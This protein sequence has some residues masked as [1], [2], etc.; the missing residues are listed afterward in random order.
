TCTLA[1]A[2]VGDHVLTATYAGDENFA[3]STSD[4]V[5]QSVLMAQT[6]LHIESH[7]PDPSV[8]SQP[9]TV[10]A[11]AWVLEPGVG[12][13]TAPI[14]VGDG[15]DSCTIPTANGSCVIVL[16]TRGPRT[17]LATYEGDADFGPS[18]E[19]MGHRVNEAPFVF[20]ENYFLLEDH[21]LA[22][23]AAEGV[24]ANDFDSDGDPI[25]VANAGTLTASGIGGI[26]VLAADGS[27]TYT[28][29]ADANG[30]ATFDYV[31]TDG[32][33]SVT[34]TA[35][36]SVAPVND[37]PTFTLAADPVWPPGMSGKEF[38]SGFAT[39][40]SL[41]GP[42]EEGQQVLGWPARIVKDPNGIFEV[43]PFVNMDG[44]LCYTLNGRG[45]TATI[46]VAAQDNGGTDD[47]G[48]DTS[49]EQMF[50]ISVGAGTDLAVTIDDGV[51]FVGVGDTLD[52]VIVVSN[53]GPDHAAGA[54]VKDLLP[55]NLIDASWTCTA[56]TGA[57]CSPGGSGD[58]DETI[59]LAPG[60][61][62]V[63]TLTATLAQSPEAPLENS[64]SVTAPSG[65]TDLNPLDD[66]ATDI[67][68]TGI[69]S[70]GFDRVDADA[71]VA[72]TGSPTR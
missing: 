65:M 63:F 58:I 47:G 36:L 17:L 25:L 49:L 35:T 29:P 20:G 57:A 37:P 15:V 24:L 27:F 18:S 64:V 46:A 3:P 11:H 54:R 66:S 48:Q 4:S 40:T 6:A 22:T 62:V 16:T 59:D 1:F 60:A 56:G 13:P 2:H 39:L 41:G 50:T 32:I 69:F 30:E 26:V 33:E 10:T 9:V 51:T 70:D 52:Y 28:P 5:I 31:V 38:H 42:D 14:V 23:S 45:G 71:E 7:T 21:T 55:E 34:G 53:N 19:T 67:D 68:V 43:A 12:D 61:N 72:A 8:P 44:S